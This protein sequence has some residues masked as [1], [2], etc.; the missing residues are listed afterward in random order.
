MTRSRYVRW[1][2]E[3]DMTTSTGLRACHEV[4]EVG[5]GAQ[6]PTG[7]SLE[8]HDQADA[9]AV[10]RQDGWKVGKT[11]LCPAHAGGRA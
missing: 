9:D 7:R 6:I 10:A 8:V 5:Q 11:V 4:L 3:C 2:Y 1:E